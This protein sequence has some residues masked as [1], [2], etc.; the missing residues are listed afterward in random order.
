MSI[1]K[2]LLPESF[3][4]ASIEVVTARLTDSAP[5]ARVLCPWC[6]DFDPTI[7]SHAASHKMCNVCMVRFEH[8]DRDELLGSTCGAACGYCGR[9]S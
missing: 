8:Q 7:N 5:P 4:F 6:P 3:A 1:P 2:F 9:C